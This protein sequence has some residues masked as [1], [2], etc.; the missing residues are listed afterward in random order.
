MPVVPS[1]LMA[2]RWD[3]NRLDYGLLCVSLC[4]ASVIQ[5]SNHPVVGLSP[6]GM[7]GNRF[8]Q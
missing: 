4:S 6:F 7:P 5:L 1:L 3:G 8:R 2:V